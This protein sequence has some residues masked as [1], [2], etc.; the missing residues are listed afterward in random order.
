MDLS[1]LRFNRLVVIEEIGRN[2]QG[3]LIWRCKCDCGNYTNVLGGNLK[4]GNT[5]SCGCYKKERT[6]ESKSKPFNDYKIFPKESCIKVFSPKGACFLID[7]DDLDK[8][9]GYRWS[10]NGHGQWYNK[11]KDLLYRFLLQPSDDMV[12]DHINGDTNDNRK[13]NLRIVTK[14]QNN[15]NIAVREN[16]TSGATG[17]SLTSKNLWHSYIN[18]KGKRYNLGTFKTKEEAIY[19]RYVAEVLIHKQFSYYLSRMINPPPPPQNYNE[20]D[21]A[22][23]NKLKLK[24]VLL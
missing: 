19:A 6:S 16:S 20:I 17:V 8:I 3:N 12:V 7:T 18:Y 11:N 24:G 9:K 23:S 1:N 21:L 14:A 2:N 13:E 4:K 5:S 15:I 10:Y 22:V